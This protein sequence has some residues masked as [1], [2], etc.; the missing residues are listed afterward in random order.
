MVNFFKRSG[1]VIEDISIQ[2]GY[3]SHTINPSLLLELLPKLSTYIEQRCSFFQG[4]GA[5][6]S[7]YILF[8]EQVLFPLIKINK[9]I[10]KKLEQDMSEEEAS[11]FWP[12]TP[13]IE[14]YPWSMF[15]SEGSEARKR[16]PEANP[17]DCLI[18]SGV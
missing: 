4:S 9:L 12:N 8:T 14:P 5:F 11:F 13:W 2:Q 3:I 1:L 6:G 10:N 17:D 15:H 16:L 18:F 7:I